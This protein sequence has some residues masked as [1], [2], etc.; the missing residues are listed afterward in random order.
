M[1]WMLM[2]FQELPQWLDN[3][4]FAVRQPLLQQILQK[5]VLVN[6]LD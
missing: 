6:K 2:K 4:S 5:I 1:E 3:G